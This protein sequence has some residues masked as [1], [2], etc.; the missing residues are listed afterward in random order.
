M[1]VVYTFTARE[2]LRSIYEYIAFTLLSPGAARNT[3]DRI[4]NPIHG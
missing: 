2:D 1:K 4:M 3:T